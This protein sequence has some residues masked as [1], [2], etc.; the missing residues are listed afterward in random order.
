[1]LIICI[2]CR[3]YDKIKR[4]IKNPPTKKQKKAKRIAGKNANL[5]IQI[6]NVSDK[7]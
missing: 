5:A 1:L 6:P 2:L 7:I 3:I 4:T